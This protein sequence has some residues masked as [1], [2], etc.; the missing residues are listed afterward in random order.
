MV[1]VAKLPCPPTT[2]GFVEIYLLTS[3]APIEKPHSNFAKISGKAIH[4][5]SK[6]TKWAAA[7][8]RNPE[9]SN[10]SDRWLLNVKLGSGVMSGPGSDLKV[11]SKIR[12]E[13]DK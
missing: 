9:I 1:W 2:T 4:F 10:P 13:R 12:L 8:I 7:V 6:D 3:L 5:R 11:F